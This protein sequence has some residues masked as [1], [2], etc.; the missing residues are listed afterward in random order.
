MSERTCEYAAAGRPVIKL[1][2]EYGSR[3][4]AVS[5]E[6]SLSGMLVDKRRMGVE[7]EPCFEVSTYIAGRYVESMILHISHIQSVHHRSQC[8]SPIRR[9][10][11]V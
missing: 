10:A 8:I 6:I 1:G 3:P 11:S 9:L 5:S 7:A 4:C 2:V